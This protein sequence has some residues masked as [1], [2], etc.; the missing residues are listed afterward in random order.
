[1]IC[2]FVSIS[3]YLL[4][5]PFCGGHINLVAGR[6][7][8]GTHWIVLTIFITRES[9]GE[10]VVIDILVILYCVDKAWRSWTSKGQKYDQK[11]KCR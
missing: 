11:C 3:L 7:I 9:S 8:C 2:V 6:A 10:N 5:Y 4:I 1:M